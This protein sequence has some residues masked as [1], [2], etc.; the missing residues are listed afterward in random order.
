MKVFPIKLHND[1]METI[2]ILMT[3]TGKDRSI[4]LHSVSCDEMSVDFES[5]LEDPDEFVAESMSLPANFA[6]KKY[7]CG[8]IESFDQVPQQP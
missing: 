6:V 2:R 1:E 8:R 7:V 3:S 5:K 4:K